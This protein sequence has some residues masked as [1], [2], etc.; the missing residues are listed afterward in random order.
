MLQQFHQN[1]NKIDR[2]TAKQTAEIEAEM[3]QIWQEENG[4]KAA[5][6]RR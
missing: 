4:A 1:V 3:D 2:T 5:A 6:S